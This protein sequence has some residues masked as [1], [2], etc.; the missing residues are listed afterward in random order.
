MHLASLVARAQDHDH[1]EDDDNKKRDSK[2]D[3]EELAACDFESDAF[4]ES[5]SPATKRQRELYN[6]IKYTWF[7]QHVESSRSDGSDTD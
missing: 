5:A 4:E 6:E 3:A 1:D 2:K 7:I